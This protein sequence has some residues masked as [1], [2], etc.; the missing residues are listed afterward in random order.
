NMGVGMIA[1]VPQESVDAALATLTDRGVDAWVGGEITERG[2]RTAG[3]ALVG[4]Y[5]G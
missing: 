1:V 2:D 5:A 4:T 3:A